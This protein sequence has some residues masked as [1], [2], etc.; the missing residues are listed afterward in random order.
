M[1]QTFKPRRNTTAGGWGHTH[2]MLRKEFEPVVRA[3][4]ARCVRCGEKI[5]PWEPWDLG[6]VDGDRSRYAG[7]EHR[8][9]NRATAGRKWPEP[10][11]ELE[12]E[13][14]VEFLVLDRLF[15]RSIY[16]SM[17]VAEQ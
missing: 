3:G 10:L 4:S 14:V 11:V 13:R 17:L 7:P 8:A 16:A 15:P 2:R 1:P 12:P 5:L 9:C 6:H